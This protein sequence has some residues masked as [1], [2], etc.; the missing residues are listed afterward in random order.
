MI[1]KNNVLSTNNNSDSK[2]NNF[3]VGIT[4]RIMKDDSLV[5]YKKDWKL[6]N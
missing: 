5:L 4:S 1:E 2:E 3:V 6:L